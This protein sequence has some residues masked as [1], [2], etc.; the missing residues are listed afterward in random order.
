M[1]NLFPIYFYPN[2][3]APPLGISDAIRAKVLSAQQYFAGQ[4]G[5]RTFSLADVRVIKGLHPTAFYQDYP[6][7]RVMED[8]DSQGIT[9]A[10]GWPPYGILVNFVDP[11]I[12]PN[13]NGGT[14]WN[15]G[16]AAMFASTAL[17][18]TGRVVEHEVG[19]AYGVPHPALCERVFTP[20]NSPTP[21]EYTWCEA[22]IM[23][24]AWN[25][26]GVFHD[27]AKDIL[28]AH[29]LMAIPLPEPAPLPEPVP[30]PAPEPVP[31]PIEILQKG[32][33]WGRGRRRKP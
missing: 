32:K 16:G 20:P 18:D 33:R 29:P 24:S 6:W 31:E 11:I 25:Y 23:W 7:R 10:I 8:L 2:D 1:A 27:Y 15:G 17:A 13:M 9:A 26:N 5:G 21:E 19:H 22:D 12:D 3:Q 30:A 14:P 4:L 28:M